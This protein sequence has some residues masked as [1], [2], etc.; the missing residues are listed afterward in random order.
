MWSWMGLG[1]G[2]GCAGWRLL[3]RTRVLLRK[4]G[5]GLPWLVRHRGW[6]SCEALA[7][8]PL[9]A[10]TDKL[11][12]MKQRLYRVLCTLWFLHPS[13]MPVLRMV[14]AYLLGIQAN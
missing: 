7:L 11:R 14:V 4:P 5:I 1:V 12:G 6:Q 8:A 3:S 2:I 13:L 9:E 10:R